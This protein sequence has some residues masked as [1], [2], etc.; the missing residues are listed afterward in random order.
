V[1]IAEAVE[2]SINNRDYVDQIENI[3]DTLN[4]TIKLI[5]KLI[6]DL[7]DNHKLTDDQIKSMLNLYKYNIED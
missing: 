5:G 6:E 4:Y 2:G 3:Q 7:H 1:S